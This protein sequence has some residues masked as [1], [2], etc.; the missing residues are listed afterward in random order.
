MTDTAPTHRRRRL[1]GAALLLVS[2]AALGG[3]MTHRV[4]IQP[5]PAIMAARAG[6]HAPG[7]NACTPRELSTLS[8]VAARFAFGDAELTENAR[9]TLDE[10]VAWLICNPT[11]GVVVRPG[12]DVHGTV[13]EQQALAG[14]RATAVA[15]YIRGHGATRAVIRILPM[16][17]PET[18]ES[19]SLVIKAEGQRW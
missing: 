8:P 13:A 16:G 14:R 4:K 17:A 6:E 18:V 1:T 9:V 3:C 15:E 7:I 10:A 11:V 12:G 19:Q 5:S 2:A